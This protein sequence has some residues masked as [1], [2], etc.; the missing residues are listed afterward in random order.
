MDF[1]PKEAENFAL[2]YCP[3][4]KSSCDRKKSKTNRVLAI[5]ALP[6]KLARGCQPPSG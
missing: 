3:Q 1:D 5:R 6:Q 4:A 2:R